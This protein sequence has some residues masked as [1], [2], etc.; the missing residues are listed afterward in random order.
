MRYDFETLVDRTHAG[1]AK[2]N[3]MRATD[4]DVPAGIVP[5]SVGDME[6]KTAPEIVEGLK[7]FLGS[8]ILGYTVPTAEYLR[9]V[10]GWLGRRHG[11]EPET[12]WIA[13]I[14]GVVPAIYTAIQAFTG[15]GDG[16]A[17]MSPVYYPFFSAVR[18]TGRTL[19][20]APLIEEN[21]SCMFDLAAFAEAAA[22][23]NVKMLLLCSPH[24]PVGR[25]WTSDELLELGRICV[26]HG[27]L[28]VSD[29]IHMDFAMPG[30]RHRIFPSLTTQFADNCILCTA[31]SKTF[32]LAGLQASNI[33]I[34]NAKLRQRFAK[35]HAAGGRHNANQ[36]G[37]AACK[38][39][40]DSCA[41]WLDQVVELIYGN[42]LAVRSF[43]GAHF[44]E[45]TVYDLQGT[46]FMWLDF[47]AWGMDHLE[48]EKFMV[49]RARCF[50]DEGYI[51]GD[52]GKG[53]ERINLA[54][55]ASAIRDALERLRQARTGA[56]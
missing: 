42:F 9:S 5:L 30:Y 11:W 37:L 36:L 16:V 8:N 24:N 12:E 33:I 44:P 53:F 15:V 4:P 27:I 31:P 39:A 55:P 19:V 54:C 52:S 51:F 38:I 46:F 56:K 21:G 18:D 32:N 40:Y 43:M 45:V 47:R 49:S 6:L 25:V 23:R 3:L 13:S 48:L 20:D 10:A 26:R 28:V 2:W 22:K 14:D 35:T 17:V 29:E 34:P 41:P 1:S 7:A 50:L